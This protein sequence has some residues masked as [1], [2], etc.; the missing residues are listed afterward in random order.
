M[1]NIDNQPNVKAAPKHDWFKK[2]ER[3]P[4]PNSDWNV[5]KSVDFRPPQTGISKIAQAEKPPLFFDELMSTPIDFSAY[6]TKHLKIDN[7]THEHLNNPEGKEYPLDLSKPLPL[8]MERGR[9]VVPI[10]YFINHDLEYL[11]GES[12]SKKYTTSTT[13]TKADKYDIPGIE[14]MVSSL[15]NPEA[16]SVSLSVRSDPMWMKI[17]ESHSS[18]VSFQ[19]VESKGPLSIRVPDRHSS[20]VCPT[21][22]Q[23][24]WIQAKLNSRSKSDHPPSPSSL[25]EV[26]INSS[27]YPLRSESLPSSRGIILVELH[28]LSQQS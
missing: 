25:S 22:W 10:D 13:K 11:R 12:S 2:P 16:R 15:W 3:P 26:L 9:Q 24:G 5:R 28:H 14:D 18:D 4:T 1:G 21:L 7:L 23:K 17:H 8:I 27:S 6:V 19:W 20:H